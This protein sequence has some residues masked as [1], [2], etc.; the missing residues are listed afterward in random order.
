MK[1]GVGTMPKYLLSWEQSVWYNLEVQADSH[2]AALAKF[3]NNEFDYED[4]MEAGSEMIE[5]TLSVEAI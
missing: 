2:F 1:D 4:V 5:G 3:E